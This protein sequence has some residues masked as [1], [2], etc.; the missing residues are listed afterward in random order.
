MLVCAKYDLNDSYLAAS[1]EKSHHDTRF[2]GDINDNIN[3][4]R[5]ISMDFLSQIYLEKSKLENTTFGTWAYYY[6]YYLIIL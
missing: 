5:D 3:F 6:Y 2:L 4:T 1:L